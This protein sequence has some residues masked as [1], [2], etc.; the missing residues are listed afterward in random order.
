[1]WLRMHFPKNMKMKGPFLSLL[2][3]TRLAPRR[4]LGMATQSQK[5]SSDSLG[6]SWLHD[7]L[8]YKGHL[9]F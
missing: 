1:M 4:S 3:C 9:Y 2:H 7:E 8:R 5:F 6:Y